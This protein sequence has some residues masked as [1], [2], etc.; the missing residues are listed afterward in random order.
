MDFSVPPR[1]DVVAATVEALKKNGFYAVAAADGADALHLALA[2]IPE[3]AEVMTMASVT[4]D[5]IGL[6]KELNESGR[7]KSVRAAFKS[8]DPKTQSRRMRAMAA[9]PEW[10]TGSVH[11]VT[12][13]GHLLIASASGSQI[14]AHVQG[15]DRVL[16]VV[17]S[18]KIVKDAEEGMRRIYEYVLPLESKRAMKAYGQGSA[19]NDLLIMNAQKPGRVT[20]ILVKEKIGF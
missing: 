3:G 12:R 9:A 10:S 17:G 2:L 8:M 19:V 1:G 14:P 13:D 15:A 4:V 16:F 7:Y 11:A 6:A 20:V 5:S 18:Q